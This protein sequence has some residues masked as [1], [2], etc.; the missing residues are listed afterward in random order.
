MEE[1]K[2]D[3]H[4]EMILN[5]Y[6]E[7]KPT[8]IRLKEIVDG[9]LRKCVSEA[10]I[11][12]TAIESRVKEENSL[13][14]KLFAK[15]YKYNSISDIT[16]ILGA[17]IITIYNDEVDKIAA[18]AEKVF[19]VDWDNSVDKR[20]MLGTK[21]FGYMSLHYICSVPKSVFY[22]P[23]MPEINQI[24]FELQMRTTLQHMWSF[25]DHDTGYKSNVEVPAQYIRKLTTL[26]GLLELADDEFTRL[27]NTINEYRKKVE[28]L[29][30]EGNFK[31]IKLDSDSFHGYID[32]GPF[33]ELNSRIA[34]INGADIVEASYDPFL[35][36]FLDMGFT[37]LEDVENMRKNYSEDAYLLAT[38]QFSGTDID[39]MTSTLGL[40]NLCIV[41]MIKNG[42]GVDKIKQ[43]LDS[44]FGPS[45]YNAE[46]ATKLLEESK[47]L[48][49]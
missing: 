20:K 6:R 43:L 42:C 48:M 4:S 31:D 35:K 41:Y 24:R 17:R 10:G 49:M 40:Q 26:A 47:W 19:D 22:D 29:I 12:V 39:I 27:R 3:I 13:I 14:G 45:D 33:D 11:A 46:N 38:H 32:I 16:D 1:K 15:G 30:K 28:N 21:S 18:L 8:Y 23:E 2:L 36:V 25:V 34:S 5:E 7:K 37:N 44:L 9:L